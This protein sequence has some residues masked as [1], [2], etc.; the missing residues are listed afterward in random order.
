MNKSTTYLIVSK[1]NKIKYLLSILTSAWDM[2]N[3]TFGYHFYCCNCFHCS[4][5]L[6]AYRKRSWHLNHKYMYWYFFIFVVCG[7]LLAT[8]VP[9]SIRNL[10]YILG[11]V[12][13]P[14]SFAL[15]SALRWY[16]RWPL[17]RFEFLACYQLLSLSYSVSQSKTHSFLN[18]QRAQ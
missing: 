3:I 5:H 16:S 8:V 1:A 17:A 15:S 2:I 14:F 9:A 11:W 7:N 10:G 6:E 4:W 12:Q 13:P 18:I